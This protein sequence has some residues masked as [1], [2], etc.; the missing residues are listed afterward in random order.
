MFPRSSGILLHLSSL[1]GPYGIGSM[2]KE[3]RHFVDFL[4]KAGERYWQLLPLVPP[5]EGASPYMSPSSAAGNPLFI[6]LEELVEMELLTW[7]D[8][9]TCRYQAPDCVDYEWVMEHHYA[10]LQKA[11]ANATPELMEKAMAFA[12]EQKD[13]LPNY[14]LFRAAHDYFGVPLADWPDEAFKQRKPEA[15]EKYKKMLKKEIG[16]YIFNQYLF[17]QQWNRLK[18]YANARNVSVIGDIPFYVSPDSVD[19]WCAPHLFRVDP[20]TM[21]ADFVAGV[22]ADMFSATGQYWGNPLYDW[23][24][25]A[26]E[27]YRWWCNRIRHTNAFYDVIRIDHFRGFHTYWE[28]PAEAESALEGKWCPG[29]RMALLDAIRENVPEAE[30]IAEDLGDID[31]N[32]Y[33]FIVSTGLP[34]M[35]VLCDAFND[36]FG[37]SAFLPHHCVPG[38][39]MY[40][41]T[42]DTPTFVQ[43][44]MDL[45]DDQQRD[46]FNRY[47]RMHYGDSIHWT[48]LSTALSSICALCMA[49]LQDVLGLGADARMNAPGTMGPQNWSWRVR[50]EALN[51]QVARGLH[52]LNSL[53][54]R[55]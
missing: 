7:A 52:E 11:Y 35:R 6:D 25:H 50:M 36:I 48:A 44:Y 41:G 23:D 12:E 1:P 47:T 34:G 20:A 53:Y 26:A 27:D 39:V 31:E 54:G 10:L 9:E 24:A 32:A 17:F 45:A 5:G 15:L 13:W 42:H 4:H 18:A 2:G 38:A 55:L 21:K 37:S 28:I 43:W 40:T 29:P 49:P 46:F 8:L 16:G 3:A 33:K 51:D 30:F 22:P 19:V 14:A